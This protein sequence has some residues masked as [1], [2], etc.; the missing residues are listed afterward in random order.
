MEDLATFDREGIEVVVG[1]SEAKVRSEIFDS[2]CSYRIGDVE[3]SSIVPIWIIINLFPPVQEETCSGSEMQATVYDY[4]PEIT[5]KEIC[6]FSDEL[7][8]FRC[9]HVGSF[10]LRIHLA[11]R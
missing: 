10:E 4:P 6:C 1:V 7:P 5:P 2:F 8:F 11:L 9:E 3:I